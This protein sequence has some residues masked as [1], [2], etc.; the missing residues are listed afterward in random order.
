MAPAGPKAKIRHFSEPLSFSDYK[1][2]S[3]DVI[4]CMVSIK[5]ALRWIMLLSYKPAPACRMKSKIKVQ[6]EL[7]YG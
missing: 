6:Q 7:I 5:K 2:Q 1:N 4:M 3:M